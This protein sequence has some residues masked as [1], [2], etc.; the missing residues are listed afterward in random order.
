MSLA[1]SSGGG[2]RGVAEWTILG[3]ARP[4][5]LSDASAPGP[6]SS[7][8]NLFSVGPDS[9]STPSEL[10]PSA[11]ASRYREADGRVPGYRRAGAT[12]GLTGVCRVFSGL[13]RLFS[14]LGRARPRAGISAFAGNF[15]T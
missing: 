15:V 1:A 6:A 11:G 14:G 7:Q 13:G 8:P 5:A 9:L 10:A 12:L 3:N 4:K 2:V